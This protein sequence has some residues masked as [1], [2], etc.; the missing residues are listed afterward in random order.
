[1]HITC[2]RNGQPHLVI[3]TKRRCHSA[4]CSAGTHNNLYQ[5]LRDYQHG[6]RQHRSC[7]TQLIKTVHDFAQC[8]NQHG[9][10]D[11]L[12]L[13]FSKAFDR[14]LH[15]RLF[16]KLQF[17]GIRAPLLQWI[18]NFLTGR[19][20][21]VVLNSKQSNSNNVIS[22]VPQGTVL[23][24]LLFL[25]YINDLPT[26]VL[27]KVGMYADDVILYS[28]ISS[29]EDCHLLQKDLELLSQWSFKWKMSFNAKKCEFLRITNK[30]NFVPFRY[31]INNDIP[32]SWL[33]SKGFYFRIFRKG[34]P[35][36]K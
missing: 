2:S 30:K 32:Y 11:V 21:Q 4:K 13:D 35:F 15:S 33:F 24:P 34:L 23:A 9:Q 18:I 14:V 5:A 10:C 7:E 28:N 12:L 31:R 3:H 6:F 26:N 17:Y 29:V 36:R 8:L 22:G 19:S 1:M 25:I 27:S 16:Y 20:Q